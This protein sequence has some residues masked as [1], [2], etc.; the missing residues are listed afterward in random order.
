MR[1]ASSSSRRSTSGVTRARARRSTSCS[2]VTWTC[3][4]AVGALSAAT[5]ATWTSTCGRSSGRSKCARWTPSY[6]VVV[7]T[8]ADG[9]RSN[10]AVRSDL[11]QTAPLVAAVGLPIQQ[12]RLHEA[13]IHGLGVVGVGG[14]EPVQRGFLPHPGPVTS[15]RRRYPLRVP[16]SHHTVW[17]SYRTTDITV[18]RTAIIG[19]V[20]SVLIGRLLIMRQRCCVA[21]F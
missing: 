6:V 17:N 16:A 11:S 2:T 14:D 5:A 21:R 9:S 3:T 19:Q 12:F 18:A 13:H 20:L 7:I 8:A 4:P 1:F 10:T 15:H